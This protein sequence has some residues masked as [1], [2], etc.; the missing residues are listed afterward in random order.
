MFFLLLNIINL[1]SRTIYNN[2]SFHYFPSNNINYANTTYQLPYSINSNHFPYLTN[3]NQ[4]HY[5]LNTEYDNESDHA[6]PLEGGQNQSK[7]EEIRAIR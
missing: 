2:S 6:I 7:I 1:P 4:L 3:Y 5:S